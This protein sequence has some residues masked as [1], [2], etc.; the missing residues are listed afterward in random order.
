MEDD[1]A[2][3]EEAL[4]FEPKAAV[5]SKDVLVSIPVAASAAAI[6][7]AA[8]LVLLACWSVRPPMPG[9]GEP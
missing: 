6:A 3:L 7:F 2:Q 5:L 8:P 9:Q 4:Q 1:L